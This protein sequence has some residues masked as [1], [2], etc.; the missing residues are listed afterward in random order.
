MTKETKNR[1]HLIYGIVLSAVAVIAGICFIVSA[2]GLYQAG[3]AT[4]TQP[5]TVETIR[6]AFSRIAI[7]VYLCLALVIGGI[8]LNIVLPPEKKKQPVEK[9]RQLILR[10][11]ESKTDLSACEEG[12][13]ASIEEQIQLRRLHK[14]ISGLL[15]A[16]ASGLFLSYACDS[17]HWH[18][19]DFNSSMV[20]GFFALMICLVIPF[21]YIVFTSFF[22]R[23]SLDRQIELMRRAN[24][25]AP[26]QGSQSPAP[27]NSCRA[28][29]IVRYAVLVFAVGILAYGLCTGGT[30]DVLAKAATICTECVGLG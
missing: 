1:I 15:L 17:N 13:R 21:I 29:T 28:E 7:P 11:L 12:L 8:I 14:L 22:C 9:N 19:T 10:R 2:Y 3:L 16:V 5:Y 30:A 23:K 27:A 20:R 26:I 4:D 18:E 24:A 25:A 6:A